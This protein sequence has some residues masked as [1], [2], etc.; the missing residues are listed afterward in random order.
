MAISDSGVSVEWL[1]TGHDPSGQPEP[2]KGSPRVEV[3]AGGKRNEAA[4]RRLERMF[5][6]WMEEDEASGGPDRWPEM[7]RMIDEDR[8]SYRK[9][10]ERG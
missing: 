9:L 6:R 10:F 4:A 5:A 3:R 2:Q 1:T 8:T 7:A